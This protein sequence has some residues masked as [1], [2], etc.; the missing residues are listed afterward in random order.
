MLAHVP[1]YN[2]CLLGNS[3]NACAHNL[4]VLPVHSLLGLSE[5]GAHMFNLLSKKALFFGPMSEL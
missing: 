1:L 2:A 5:L 4:T 3:S